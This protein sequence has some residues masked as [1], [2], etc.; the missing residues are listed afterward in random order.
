MCRNFLN[1]WTFAWLY[2]YIYILQIITMYYN[3]DNI[4]TWNG[5]LNNVAIQCVVWP[6]WNLVGALKYVFASKI[7]V[8]KHSYWSLQNYLISCKWYR[9]KCFQAV[10]RC[11]SLPSGCRESSTLHRLLCPTLNTNKERRSH[12]AKLPQHAQNGSKSK[13]FKLVSEGKQ[14]TFSFDHL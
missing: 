12:S 11:L 2:V 7:H 4:M 3:I 9:K 1:P 10:L 6:S 13:Y 14:I 8:W 5:S